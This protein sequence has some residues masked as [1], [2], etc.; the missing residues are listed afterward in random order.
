MYFDKSMTFIIILRL[1][2]DLIPGDWIRMVCKPLKREWSSHSI[3]CS[4]PSICKLIFWVNFLL[5]FLFILQKLPLFSLFE[6]PNLYSGKVKMPDF[7][8]MAT[9]IRES[10]IPIINYNSFP[11]NFGLNSWLNQY[12]RYTK[13]TLWT[14][15]SS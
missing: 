12:A 8:N 3:R 6:F 10:F 4:R 14:R 7:N 5:S 15:T 9:G 13:K 1:Y 11:T 2:K